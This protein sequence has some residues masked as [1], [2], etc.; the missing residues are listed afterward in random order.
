MRCG[1]VRCGAAVQV[2]CVVDRLTVAAASDS[3]T[4][5]AARAARWTSCGCR[6]PS[7]ATSAT[8]SSAATRSP[9]APCPSSRPP[10]SSARRA[11]TTTP[12]SRSC[13]NSVCFFQFSHCGCT[14]FCTLEAAVDAGDSGFANFT[15]S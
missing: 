12:S 9:T 11:C 10:S 13:T 3:L 14:A 15:F 7:S 2:F 1:A 8:C 4:V 5:K 6:R